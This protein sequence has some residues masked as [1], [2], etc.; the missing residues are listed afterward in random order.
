MTEEE[1]KT[2]EA[3]KQLPLYDEADPRCDS[4]T[5]VLDPTET[6]DGVTIVPDTLDKTVLCLSDRQL[7]PKGAIRYSTDNKTFIHVT[8]WR[9]R[10]GHS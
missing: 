9:R 1:L 10:T 7:E 5:R 8:F 3:L 6:Y 4:F 2:L